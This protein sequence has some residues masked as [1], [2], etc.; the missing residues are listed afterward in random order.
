NF[1]QTIPKGGYRLL[2]PALPVEP[3]NLGNGAASN[4]ASAASSSVAVAAPTASKARWWPWALT[5]TMAIL[6][7]G[8][9]F[10]TFTWFQRA[11]QLQTS[12]RVMLAVL[13]FQNLSSDPDQQFFADGLS[14]EMIAQ[15]GRLPSDK[16]SVIAW[17]SMV[18][19]KGQKKTDNQVAWELGAN[20]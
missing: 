13:P 15:L 4:P 19:F 7:L 6:L 5:V 1:I 3:A 9:A 8:G 2:I 11:N 20:Y 10:V 12:T 14:A 18:K 16:I 17:D